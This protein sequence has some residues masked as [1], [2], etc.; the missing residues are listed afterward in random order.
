MISTNRR[1][2]ERGR[3]ILG[4]KVGAQEVTDEGDYEKRLPVGTR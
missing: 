4:G 2:Q 3:R 1:S